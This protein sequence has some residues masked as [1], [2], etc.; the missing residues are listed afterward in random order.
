[1]FVGGQGSWRDFLTLPNIIKIFNPNLLGYS[2]GDSF[3]YHENSQFNVAEAR[4]S[5]KDLPFMARVLV[6]KMLRDDRI[7]IE[8]NWKVRLN[9][10]LKAVSKS[11]A[12][13]FL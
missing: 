5:S 10:T 12:I 3:S 11:I 7:N 9:P 1:M 6:Q 4:A 13:L 2:L 8:K